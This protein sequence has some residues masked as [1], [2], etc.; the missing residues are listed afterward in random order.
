MKKKN[1]LLLGLTMLLCSCQDYLDK[2]ASNDM[3]IDK[4]FATV[5]EA[6]K[7]MNDI[8]SEM[9]GN[10]YNVTARGVIYDCAADDGI[11]GLAPLLDGQ[12]PVW[13]VDAG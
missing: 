13:Y 9:Y 12:S 8:Y 2:P 5:I 3:D 11:G 7:V 6:K 4:A 10:A 1:Y